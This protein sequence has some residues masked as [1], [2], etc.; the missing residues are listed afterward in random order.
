MEQ[1]MQRA[2]QG[3]GPERTILVI[4]PNSN[5][6]V[7]AGLD[8]AL[9]PLRLPGGPA[10]ACTTLEAGPLGIE[11]QHDVE[12][13]TLPLAELVAKSE[14]DAFVIACFSDPGLHVC[15]EAT[16]K[17]VLGI[18]ECAVVTALTRGDRFGIV[19]ILD[20]SLPRHARY[21]R[22]MGVG[23]RFAGERALNLRV[24]ELAHEE[25]TWARLAEVGRALKEQDRADVLILGCAGM[26]RYRLELEATLGIPVVDPTQAAVTMA[27]GAVL[28]AG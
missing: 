6:E 13:V 27:M 5:G 17:P 20:R 11:S 7:T 1:A 10:I 4:N 26:A 8:R 22:Q 15:R 18:A 19:A 12:A 21:L 2:G 24:H 28:L 3:T 23:P 9:Q 16:K 25:R 14:A